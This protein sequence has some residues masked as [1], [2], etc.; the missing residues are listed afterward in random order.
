MAE[1]TFYQ[2][3]L[4]RLGG[5][6]NWPNAEVPVEA[7]I[8]ELIPE[9]C[10]VPYDY[11]FRDDPEAMAECTLLVQEYL[12]LDTIWAN[13]DVYNFEAEAMGVPIKFYP[14]HCPDFNRNDPFIKDRDDLDKIKFTGLDK[15]RFPYL[16]DYIKAYKK[17]TGT[18]TFPE[19]SAPWTLAGNLYGI[20]NLIMDCYEDPDFVRELLNR[21]VED[22]H[23]PMYREF[24]KHC[25]GFNTILLGDAFTSVPIV[26]MDIVDN[27]IRP[28]LERELTSL[29]MPGIGLLDTAF[30]GFAALPELEMRRYI[31][32]V[33]WS[34][35]S[36]M[37]MDPDLSRLSVEK[38]REIA[39]ETQQLLFTG[40]DAKFTEFA[41]MDEAIARIKEIILKGKKGPTPMIFLFNC[42]NTGIDPKRAKILVQAARTFAQPDADENT[43]FEIREVPAFQE[44]LA[45]KIHN[46]PE[47]YSFNW[48]QHSL[49]KDV[50]R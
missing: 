46:N 12:D 43:E 17:Y 15:G 28:N 45:E 18:D 5:I 40:M 31:D 25:P 39:T 49:Y 16:L 24:A 32:F 35:H 10:K 19:L 7:L 36:F 30:F 20:E 21:I 3:T 33:I 37:A 13:T 4:E 11:I 23:T 29:N 22:F 2:K 44:F 8:T 41:P 1:K 50:I 42:F 48:L 9:M 34:N 27:F 6:A 47:Q 38:C 14:D 26:T